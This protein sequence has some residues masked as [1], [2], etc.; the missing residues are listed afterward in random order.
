[1]TCALASAPS[2]PM[3]GPAS[4]L[5]SARTTC[6]YGASLQF[7]TAASVIALVNTILLPSTR[8]PRSDVFIGTVELLP[9]QSRIDLIKLVDSAWYKSSS[10]G[11]GGGGGG[12]SSI[13]D[14]TTTAA[15]IVAGS[16]SSDYK[17]ILSIAQV[18]K[19]L[20]LKGIDFLLKALETVRGNND[21]TTSTPITLNSVT[22]AVRRTEAQLDAR[23]IGF[24]YD[25][26][27]LTA[28]IPLNDVC[29]ENVVVGGSGIFALADGKLLTPTRA[30]GCVV[31]H[32]GDVAHGVTQH[33]NGIRYGLFCLVSR[34]DM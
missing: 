22:F 28:Q 10:G 31:A 9:Q 33:M 32:H 20:S 26:A 34:K 15:S 13:D 8:V 19:S 7:T 11:S 23:W 3:H 5:L 14:I 17:L 29:D 21:T 1:M 30:P 6:A 27:G 25:T 4:E 12:S 2:A 18:E 16:T 24:H